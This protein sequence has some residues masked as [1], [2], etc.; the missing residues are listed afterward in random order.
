MGRVAYDDAYQLQQRLYDTSPD[1]HL[2]L[3]EHNHVFTL[4]SSGSEDH[5]L[6]DPAEVGADLI[7]ANRGGDITY[8]GPGQLVGY[9][10]L[11]V[12]GK[13][14]G[15][16][17]DTVAYVRS[18]EQLIID[19]LTIWVCPTSDGSRSTPE[20]GSNRVRRILARS[21]RSASV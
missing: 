11:W 15:G 18:V 20:Y 6:V 14:G 13:R 17:A 19:T 7:K 4:G 10:I 1:N 3:L 8:H 16:M 12:P 9:P 2:L 21:P 5:L